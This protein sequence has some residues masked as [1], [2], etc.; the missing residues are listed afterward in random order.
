MIDHQR[1]GRRAGHVPLAAKAIAFAEQLAGRQEGQ[2]IQDALVA[3]G[4]KVRGKA[5]HP[6]RFE[7]L[8]QG[9]FQPRA[10]LMLR[11]ADALLELKE[12]LVFGHLR[13]DGLR[14]GAFGEPGQLFHRQMVHLHAGLRQESGLVQA[15]IAHPLHGIP[16]QADAHSSQRPNQP[17]GVA[18]TPHLGQRARVA[19]VAGDQ[20]KLAFAA[21]QYI[22]QVLHAMH[23]MIDLVLQQVHATRHLALVA[24]QAFQRLADAV[25]RAHAL[26]EFAAGLA[27]RGVA[28]EEFDMLAGLQEGDVL[29]LAVNINQLPAELAQDVQRHGAAIDATGV[30][31]GAAEFARQDARVIAP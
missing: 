30:L 18:P 29:A 1:A 3:D 15:E 11:R 20:M 28:V 22:R 13:G 8:A 14:W 9:V 26:G 17:R 27:E 7:R 31:A 23:A 24:Q 2:R 19:I 4:H 16:E 12:A 25:Q 10:G 5:V 21:Q 6:V